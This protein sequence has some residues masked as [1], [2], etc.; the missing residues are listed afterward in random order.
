MPRRIRRFLGYFRRSFPPIRT[1]T[2]RLPTPSAA[3]T[4]E[5]YARGGVLRHQ[6]RRSE[7]CGVVG[8]VP[9]DPGTEGDRG[10]GCP[11]DPEGS[12][13]RCHRSRRAIWLTP[14]TAARGSVEE[15]EMVLPEMRDALKEGKVLNKPVADSVAAIDGGGGGGVPVES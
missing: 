6:E 3:Y 15:V 11:A 14:A 1:W 9:F 2:R 8:S 4:N 10:D 5:R 13:D 12:I 7:A